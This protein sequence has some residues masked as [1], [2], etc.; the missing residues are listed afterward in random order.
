MKPKAFSPWMHSL[1]RAAR[2]TEIVDLGINDIRDAGA[3]VAIAA[4]AVVGVPVFVVR[5]LYRLAVGV[6]LLLWRTYQYRRHGWPRCVEAV[7]AVADCPACGSQK[8]TPC[9]G[10]DVHLARQPNVHKYRAELER[11]FGG[12]FGEDWR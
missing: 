11:R 9:F 2:R 3:T 8:G 1:K 5:G 4:L 7:V 12:D 10:A 6:S